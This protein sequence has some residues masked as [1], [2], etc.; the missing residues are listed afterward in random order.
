MVLDE[1]LDQLHPFAGW[2]FLQL[3]LL[4]LGQALEPVVVAMGGREILDLL[5]LIE[6]VDPAVEFAESALLVG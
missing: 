4:C 2:F 5:R 6:F 1:L 3:V